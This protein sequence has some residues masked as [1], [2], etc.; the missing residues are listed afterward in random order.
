MNLQSPSGAARLT[1]RPEHTASA[2][3]FCAAHHFGRF[4]ASLLPQKVI[5]SASIATFKSPTS[6]FMLR[7]GKVP[8]GAGPA[9]RI[10]EPQAV[11]DRPTDAR[12]A[13]GCD[14]NTRFVT[15]HR[16]DNGFNSGRV[17]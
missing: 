14:S 4:D 7:C 12:F 13:S 1:T 2:Q 3:H 15:W 9:V 11:K 17:S 8:Y 10:I 16:P 5:G 6:G